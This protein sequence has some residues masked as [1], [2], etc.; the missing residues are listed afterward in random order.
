MMQRMK[1]GKKK[2]FEKTV[3][4]KKHLCVC[5]YVCVCARARVGVVTLGAGY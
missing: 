4:S 1:K 5:V 3:L 2:K